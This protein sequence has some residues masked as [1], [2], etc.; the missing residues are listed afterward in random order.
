MWSEREIIRE[1]SQ[2]ERERE[3]E[4]EVKTSKNLS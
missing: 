1:D 3:R 4:R 2:R